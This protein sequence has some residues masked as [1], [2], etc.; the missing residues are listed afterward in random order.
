MIPGSERTSG[1]GRR[2]LKTAPSRLVIGNFEAEVELA[3]ASTP[4]PHPPLP[5]RLLAAISQAAAHPL[6]ALA[7]RGDRMWLPAAPAALH[8]HLEIVSGELWPRSAEAMLPWCET[9]TIRALR[10]G[11]PREAD[12]LDRPWIERLTHLAPDPAIVAAVNHRRFGDDIALRHGWRLGGTRWVASIDELRDAL[13]DVS[14]GGENSAWIVR[15]PLAAAGRCALRRRGRD[16]DADSEIYV[17]RL[18]ARFGELHFQPWV[19]RR[20]D[21]STA[22]I[23]GAAGIRLFPPHR[24]ECDGNGIFRAA[25]VDDGSALADVPRKMRETSRAAAAAVARALAGAGYAGA[26]T[27]DAF[28][29]ETS[30]G[31]AL[32]PL[33]EVNARLSF[34]LLARA[35]M[36]RSKAS[37]YRLSMPPG[38]RRGRGRGRGRP[39]EGGQ[40][41]L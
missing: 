17:S 12:R 6:G 3:R 7:G 16:L 22:G 4:G 31:L 13:A 32:Q 38:P 14:L 24:C 20:A 2:P 5:R 15:A 11:A 27:V 23:V 40:P 39:P 36:E 29:F 10:R 33:S 35:A 9:E 8:N 19:S 1:E 18:L 28:V 21:F 41:D 30:A 37:R 26:F 34:G 25:I